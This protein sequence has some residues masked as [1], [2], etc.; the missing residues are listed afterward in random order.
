[1]SPLVI[2]TLPTYLACL[3]H[4]VLS[5]RALQVPP[6]ECVVKAGEVIFVPRGWW[7]ACL[8]LETMTIAGA[9]C[10]GKGWV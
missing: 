4:A 3:T 10:K 2:H 5:S 9:W 8:N 1:M 7:H 6:L